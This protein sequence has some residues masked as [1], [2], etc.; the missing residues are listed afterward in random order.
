LPNIASCQPGTKCLS[1]VCQGRCDPAN[2]Q[3]CPPGNLCLA[4][5]G[6]FYC[7]PDTSGEGGGT[8][9]TGGGTSGTG[10]GRTGTGGGVAVVGG[11][12]AGGN[13][14]VNNMGCGCSGAEATLPFAL[15]GLALLSRRRRA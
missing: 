8:A 14:N 10:G 7:T 15:L 1:G 11:G 5:A 3:S 12:T 6:S 9:G 13:V 2:A 4:A